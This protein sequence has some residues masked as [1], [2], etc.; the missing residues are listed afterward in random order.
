ML[1]VVFIKARK[2]GEDKNHNFYHFVSYHHLLFEDDMKKLKIWWWEKEIWSFIHVFLVY[3]SVSSQFCLLPF[4]SFVKPYLYLISSRF[5]L[6]CL[7]FPP[8]VRLLQ[9]HDDRHHQD[10]YYFY[11]FIIWL[12]EMKF[13]DPPP[14]LYLTPPPV[15]LPWLFLPK[16]KAGKQRYGEM[17]KVLCKN[18]FA[19]N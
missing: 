18:A 16:T 9:L 3:F 5:S 19:L 1:L 12:N 14:R 10:P 13:D 8:P 15:F 4:G 2:Q 11:F 17:I 7:C 6:T